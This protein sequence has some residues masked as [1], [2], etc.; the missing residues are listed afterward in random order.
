M[1]PPLPRATSLCL[2]F[3]LSLCLPNLS[4]HSFSFFT[5]LS[6]H[7]VSSSL[8][9]PSAECGVLH[10]FLKPVVPPV[11]PV[12][13]HAPVVA[14]A[15]E[16]PLSQCAAGLTMKMCNVWHS[17][18][19]SPNRRGSGYHRAPP[20]PASV[21][22]TLIMAHANECA[23]LKSGEACCLTLCVEGLCVR[24]CTWLCF[25]WVLA[26]MRVCARVCVQAVLLFRVW[27]WELVWILKGVCVPCMH[28][29]LCTAGINHQANPLSPFHSCNGLDTYTNSFFI[30]LFISI[31]SRSR[32]CI[33]D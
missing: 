33:K 17:W 22:L 23:A 20:G 9:P 14:T 10:L 28:A 16:V 27:V 24:V 32:P 26:C 13:L 30:L 12:L 15:A 4:P 29:C 2:S 19:E 7:L 18:N 25:V 5:S 21:C 8:Y 1:Q 31:D 6:P 3:P 11:S